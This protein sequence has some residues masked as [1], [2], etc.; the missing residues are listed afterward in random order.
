MN[1]YE[2]VSCEITRKPFKNCTTMVMD[3]YTFTICQTILT[4]VSLYCTACL[5]T[6]I[7]RISLLMSKFQIYYILKNTSKKNYK[8]LYLSPLLLCLNQKLHILVFVYSFGNAASVLSMLLK[9]LT[10]KTV[11]LLT[12]PIFYK[13]LCLWINF[14]NR[15]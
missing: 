14:L 5:P 11:Q 10:W 8:R 4:Q 9:Q 2:Q 15:P 1:Y 7:S 6:H 12:V 3:I 13:P